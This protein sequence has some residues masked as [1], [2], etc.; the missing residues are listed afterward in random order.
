MPLKGTPARRRRTRESALRSRGY[1]ADPSPFGEC[2]DLILPAWR[3]ETV[4]RGI[5]F[6]F[7]KFSR[8]I[9]RNLLDP[10]SLQLRF[11]IAM[12][13]DAGYGSEIAVSVR[14]EA[15]PCFLLFHEGKCDT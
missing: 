12:I 3:L 7:S 4:Y 6:R 8:G 2:D 9:T 5:G 13:A 11:H 14:R 1:R 10:T 15:A